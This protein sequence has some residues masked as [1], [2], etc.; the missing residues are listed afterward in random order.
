MLRLFPEYLKGEELFGLTVHAVLRIAESVSRRQGAG[1]T[2]PGAR[3]GQRSCLRGVR[4]RPVSTATWGGELSGLL[5]PL[6][7]S[8]LDGAAAHDQPHRLCQI[9]TENPHTLQTVSLCG[10]ATDCRCGCG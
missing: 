2:G 6:W 8:S 3:W 1:G 5:I 9:R 7:A 4:H 10:W